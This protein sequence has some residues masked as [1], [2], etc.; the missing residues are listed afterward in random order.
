MDASDDTD[1]RV[2]FETTLVTA[3]ARSM[4]RLMHAAA[5]MAQSSN[6]GGSDH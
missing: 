1:A 4:G 6:D 5:A 3:T 2:S